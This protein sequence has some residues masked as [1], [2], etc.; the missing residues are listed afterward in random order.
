MW[1][2][3]TQRRYCKH[4][5]YVTLGSLGNRNIVSGNSTVNPMGGGRNFLNLPD[6]LEERH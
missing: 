6:K 1:E 2:V 5:C 4:H 3:R